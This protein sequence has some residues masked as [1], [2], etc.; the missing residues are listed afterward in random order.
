LHRSNFIRV[1][2][3]RLNVLDWGGAGPALVLVHGMTDSPHIFDD[4]APQL[5]RTFHVIAYARRGHG[6]SD[7]PI[8]PYDQATLVEDLQQL[9]AASG[10]SRAYLL[11]WSMGGNEITEFAAKYPERVNGLIY[12]E[13]AYDW[14]YPKYQADFPAINPDA[15]ALGSLDAYRAWYRAA[16]FGATPWTPGLEAYLRDIT[17]IN[18]DGR[19]QPVPSGAVLD[20]VAASN[21]HSSRD[22]RHVRAPVLAIYASSLL[23]IDSAA[24]ANT[25]MSEDWERH[26]MAAFR[27]DSIA[28]VHSELAQVTVREFPRTAHMSILVLEQAAI[29]RAIEEFSNESASGRT[30]AH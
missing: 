9:L 21:A 13:A 5:A 30:Q 23:P 14:S 29:V 2:G 10:I 27:R 6:Q 7:A 12:L 19:V 25:R 4:A 11:G 22:Y 3:V 15:T 18:R 1:N 28:R 17:R 26:V 24:P 20:A 16:W 8:G